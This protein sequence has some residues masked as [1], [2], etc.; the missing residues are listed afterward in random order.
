MSFLRQDVIGAIRNS[1]CTSCLS[2]GIQAAKEIEAKIS[3]KSWDRQRQWEMKRDALVAALQALDRTDVAMM[4][5]AAAYAEGRKNGAESE[6]QWKEVM[7]ETRQIW[8]K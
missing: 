4:K 7:W 1:E 6:A 8:T 2:P 5:L 3:D